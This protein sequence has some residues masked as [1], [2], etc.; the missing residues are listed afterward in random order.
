M[1]ASKKQQQLEFPPI[2]TYREKERESLDTPKTENPFMF[3]F[4]Y[5][6][7]NTKSGYKDFRSL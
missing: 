7:L 5:L 3:V 4:N 1:Q 2:L 6:S